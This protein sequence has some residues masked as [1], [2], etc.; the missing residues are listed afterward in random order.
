[1]ERE[2]D[3]GLVTLYWQTSRRVGHNYSV[4]VHML[5]SENNIVA[6]GDGPPEMGSEPLR[7]GRRAR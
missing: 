6:Q 2:N 4:Y 7:S 5:D 1:M 3:Q